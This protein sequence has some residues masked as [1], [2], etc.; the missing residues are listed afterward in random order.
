MYAPTARGRLH[1]GGQIDAVVGG[2]KAKSVDIPV[3]PAAIIPLARRRASKIGAYLSAA[4]L[5]L[6]GR[7]WEGG[8]R[9]V[10]LF[11]P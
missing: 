5:H 1:V 8:R 7:T 9:I 6:S 11:S 2:G 10:P 3:S 4:G